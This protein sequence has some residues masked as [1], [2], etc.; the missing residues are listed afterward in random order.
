[1]KNNQNGEVGNEMEIFITL[2][3]YNNRQWREKGKPLLVAYYLISILTPLTTVFNVFMRNGTYPLM[4]IGTIYQE[5]HK[6]YL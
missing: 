6:K 5:G 2:T 3:K 4:I 1:M